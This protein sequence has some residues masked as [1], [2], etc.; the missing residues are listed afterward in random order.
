[1]SRACSELGARVMQLL[2]R[3]AQPEGASGDR[4]EHQS[5]WR[6]AEAAINRA[7]LLP[8][9]TARFAPG[10]SS[11]KGGMVTSKRSPWS[12]TIW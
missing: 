12:V 2:L 1:M 3:D 10:A 4:S 9:F 8:Q 7:R 11:E 6:A 5:S